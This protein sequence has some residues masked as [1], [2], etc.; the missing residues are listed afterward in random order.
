LF[1]HLEKDPHRK[2]R[3]AM[4]GAF[5]PNAATPKARQ[6][7]PAGKPIQDMPTLKPSPAPCG[8]ERAGAQC[9]GP[10]RAPPFP[11]GSSSAEHDL[12][13]AC[14]KLY[15]NK[16]LAVKSFYERSCHFFCAT[17]AMRL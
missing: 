1:N 11:L 9:Q 3:D 12:P 14:E 6:A 4:P 8:A 16:F 13:R 7:E 10:S 5:A 2:Q 15:S 17:L